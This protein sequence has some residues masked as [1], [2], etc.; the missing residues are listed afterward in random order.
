MSGHSKW[1]KIHRQKGATD[2]KRGALFTKLGKAIT[3]AAK[4][5]GGDLDTNFR[6]RLA[7]EKAKAANMPNDNIEK[8]IKRGT[9]ELDGGPIESATY[10]GFGPNNIAVIIDCLT[11]NRNRTSS[12]IK[13]IFSKHN[14]S[15][16]G[17]NSVSWMFEQK[18][19]IKVDQLTDKFELELIDSGAQ[20]IKKIDDGIEIYTNVKNLKKVS[21]FLE[22]KKIKVESAEIEWLPKEKK[23]IDKQQQNAIEKF[24]DDLDDNEDV[25][26]YYSNAE[27]QD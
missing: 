26:D 3:V 23:I 25:N 10:E 17:P 27:I 14:G 7:I 12:D 13:H 16:G 20:D 9:G 8:A 15:L 5:G 19:V 21:D 18:G 6:L 4:L 2:A 1:N 24:F 11:D 22:T